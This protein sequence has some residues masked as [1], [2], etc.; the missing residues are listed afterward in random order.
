M[1][2]F[3]AWLRRLLGGEK[4]ADPGSAV[5][6]PAPPG[7]PTSLAEGGNGFALAMFKKLGQRPGNL[8]FSPFSIRTALAMAQAG[9]RG[10][11]A[12]QMSEVLRISALEEPAEV[13]LAAMVQRPNALRDRTSEISAVNSLWCQEGAPLHAG[14]LDLIDR[15]YHGE[16]NLVDFRRDAERARVTINRWVE[17][18]T[19]QEIRELVASGALDAGTRLV[20]VNAVYFKGMW[21]SQ[22]SRAATRDE[23]F[24]LGGG[25]VVQTPLMHQKQAAWYVRG[26]GYQAVDLVYR[27]SGLSMLVILPDQKDGLR[28]LEQQLSTGIL[29]APVTQM[30]LCAVDLYLPRFTIAWGTLDVSGPLGALGMT[31]PFDS[32]RADFSGINGCQAPHDEALHVSAVLHKARIEVSEEG[33]EAAAATAVEMRLLGSAGPRPPRQTPVVRVDHPFLFAIRERGRGAILF[34]GRVAD[35]TRES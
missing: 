3:A 7:E 35:P 25:A 12:S 8:L 14:F 2:S 32:A 23:P 29:Q 28:D 15:H 27:G 31:L 13:V 16:A 17:D 34:L 20:L 4:V 10:E 9:A 21:V 24:Y 33:T 30:S 5:P 22:F 11:T 6:P 1:G 18:K 19:R 26:A